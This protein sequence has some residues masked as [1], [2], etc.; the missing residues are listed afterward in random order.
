MEPLLK[1]KAASILESKQRRAAEKAAQNECNRQ[2]EELEFLEHGQGSGAE[3][4]EVEE[5]GEGASVPEEPLDIDSVPDLPVLVRLVS[6]SHKEGD[7]MPMRVS[8]RVS[9]RYMIYQ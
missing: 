1:I 7:P 8:Q 9:T 6:D 5:G 3:D 4:E 2:R